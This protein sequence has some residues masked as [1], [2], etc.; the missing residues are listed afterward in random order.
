M[1]TDIVKR[2]SHVLA[3]YRFGTIA[4]SGGVDSITLAAFAQMIHG[5]NGIRMVHAISPAVP[6]A[7]TSRL[8]HYAT[9]NNW[10]LTEI[11][12]GE[13][14]DP[15][16]R[17]NPINRCFYCKTN[18]YKAIRELC[19]GTIM[20]GT[21]CDDL[22]DY[23]PGLVAAEN[24]QV[25]HP[26]VEAEM[27]KDAVRTLA[28]NLGMHDFAEL[29]ASPCLSSR[30]QTG[31][32]IDATQLALVEKLETW[33]QK[34]VKPKT[35]RCRIRREGLVIELDV[36]TL[37][38]LSQQEQNRIIKFAEEQLPRNLLM[39]VHIAL[40]ERGSAF[41]DIRSSKIA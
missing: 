4:V 1:R 18:L 7:A 24:Y 35:V 36:E 8:R 11:N 10:N 3:P 20:S 31:I 37:D 25:R 41:V 30:I 27:N 28:H 13:F 29:P 6:V 26:Y 15:S 19:H 34:F 40:Y 12:A 16:Y 32:E 38:R 9:A 5:A 23:R 14:S 39:T 33:L 2:L 17:A 21:N 22:D